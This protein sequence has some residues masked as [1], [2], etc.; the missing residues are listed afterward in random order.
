MQVSF[1]RGNFVREMSKGA[2]VDNNIKQTYR[3]GSYLWQDHFPATALI[4]HLYHHTAPTQMG[5]SALSRNQRHLHRGEQLIN[6]PTFLG[7][8][9]AAIDQQQQ[10]HQLQRLPAGD[11]TLP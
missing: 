5:Q 10:L 2:L 9:K 4:H 8:A 7:T 3:L 1:H 11:I 6:L